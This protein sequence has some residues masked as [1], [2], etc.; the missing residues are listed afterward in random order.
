MAVAAV[1]LSKHVSSGI[2]LFTITSRQFSGCCRLHHQE[3]S[4]CSF[5]L[6]TDLC[7]ACKL[8]VCW[9]LLPLP[10]TSLWHNS[11]TKGRLHFLFTSLFLFL[12][13]NTALNTVFSVCHHC[14]ICQ[15]CWSTC[16]FLGRRSV[17]VLSL[18]LSNHIGTRGVMYSGRSLPLKLW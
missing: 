7:L 9:V 5:K 18:E 3:W 2:F 8:I 14:R 17:S 15:F 11:E 1:S 6:T 16:I 13:S 4:V 10:H 12:L